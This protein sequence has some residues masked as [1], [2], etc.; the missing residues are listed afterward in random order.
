MPIERTI[1]PDPSPENAANAAPLDP[2]TVALNRVS[3]ATEKLTQISALDTETQQRPENQ[4]VLREAWTDVVTEARNFGILGDLDRILTAAYTTLSTNTDILAVEKQFAE[5]RIQDVE[6]PFYNSPKF[7]ELQP[8]FAYLRSIYYQNGLDHIREQIDKNREGRGVQ[9]SEV[10]AWE[11]DIKSVIEE[12]KRQEE[13]HERMRQTGKSD[14]ERIRDEIMNLERKGGALLPQDEDRLHSLE[15]ERDDILRQASNQGI[16]EDVEDTFKSVYS[17]IRKK[18]IQD[19]V[20]HFAAYAPKLTANEDIWEQ[21]RFVSLEDRYRGVRQYYADTLRPVMGRYMRKE[22]QAI[23]VKDEDQARMQLGEDPGFDAFWKIHREYESVR[24]EEPEKYSIDQYGRYHLEW[25]EHPLEIEDAILNFIQNSEEEVRVGQRVQ[26]IFQELGETRAHFKEL[27]KDASKRFGRAPRSEIDP[28]SYEALTKKVLEDVKYLEAVRWAVFAGSEVVGRGGWQYYMDAMQD[29]AAAI[30]P[31]FKAIYL[32]RNGYFPL[33]AEMFMDDDGKIYHGGA[34]IYT[35]LMADRVGM[36]GINKRD[37]KNPAAIKLAAL[38]KKRKKEIIEAVANKQLKSPAEILETNSAFIGGSGKKGLKEE[39]LEKDKNETDDKG[40]LAWERE[41]PEIYTANHPDVIAGKKKVDPS[42]IIAKKEIIRFKIME[43]RLR[44]EFDN[45]DQDEL[46]KLHSKPEAY[47]AL[48]KQRAEQGYKSSWQRFM[49]SIEQ[50]DPDSKKHAITERYKQEYKPSWRDYK[51]RFIPGLDP[52]NPYR[53]NPRELLARALTHEELI[54]MYMEIP[55]FY[56]INKEI[57][58]ELEKKAIDIG[59]TDQQKKRYQDIQDQLDLREDLTKRQK[60]DFRNEL[61]KLQEI[62][63]E[64]LEREDLFRLHK[65]REKYSE[66]I[67]EDE[68]KRKQRKKDA[69][70]QLSQVDRLS[71]VWGLS[72]RFA[73]TIF[74]KDAEGYVV[75]AKPLILEIRDRIKE[76]PSVF[77]DDGTQRMTL[78][79]ATNSGKGLFLVMRDVLT[80]IGVAEKDWPVYSF[81]LSVDGTEREAIINVICDKFS[82]TRDGFRQSLGLSPNANSED[83]RIAMSKLMEHESRVRKVLEIEL[84]EKFDKDPSLGTIRMG[85]AGQIDIKRDLHIIDGLFDGKGGIR[86]KR[87]INAM[88]S[89]IDD[90]IAEKGAWNLRMFASRMWLANEEEQAR[91]QSLIYVLDKIQYLSGLNGAENMRT[92][93][94]GGRPQGSD[95]SND[96]FLKGPLSGSSNFKVLETKDDFQDYGERG[97]LSKVTEL[98]DLSEHGHKTLRDD[99]VRKVI[100][101]FIK[102]LDATGY[103]QAIQGGEAQTAKF[104]NTIRWLYFKRWILEGR[105][106]VLSLSGDKEAEKKLREMFNQDRKRG[107][108]EYKQVFDFYEGFRKDYIIQLIEEILHEHGENYVVFPFPT[109]TIP[110]PDGTSRTVKLDELIG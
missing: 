47:R 79:E 10:G 60:R 49:D 18:R 33:I 85:A 69:T 28:E 45:Q 105:D 110:N 66:E 62:A 72:S 13:A 71:T 58:E 101:P 59:L 31:E 82:L 107:G 97:A 4:Q 67:K 78:A 102:M 9:V 37:K 17:E 36:T 84:R 1:M 35:G 96:G 15:L 90:F 8:Y 76:I 19:R 75:D 108:G 106:D 26:G 88:R 41:L 42:D 55:T 52:N 95:K 43:E 25:P 63:E 44:A 74:Y 54:D 16:L 5:L 39:L 23:Q 20:D 77:N 104:E 81:Y 61:K 29:F 22:I 48:V 6:T 30:R 91:M 93:G 98:S 34:E 24:R 87:L 68:Y 51:A 94:P 83:E 80:Q 65:A 50:L 73:P 46:D 21:D 11:W 92:I 53:S 89:G 56:S 86:A 7:R 38:Q 12:Q 40:K 70:D 109:V 99:H 64:T 103:M 57:V 14:F 2:K 27:I 100:D 3:S 32:D